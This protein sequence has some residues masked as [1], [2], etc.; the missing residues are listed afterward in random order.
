MGNILILDD[1]RELL[2]ELEI[3]L[4]N[5]GH[6]P[7]CC[8]NLMKARKA[9]NSGNEFHL[10]ILDVRLDSSDLDERGGFRFAEEI[11]KKTTNL[12]I[13]FVTAVTGDIERVRGRALGCWD[14]I[15]KSYHTEEL[16]LVI[17]NILTRTNQI[18]P[19]NDIRK[20]DLIISTR[21]QYVEWREQRFSPTYTE[22]SLIVKLGGHAG[23]IVN[24]YD[25]LE[26][27]ESENL[28]SV[29]THIRNI[30]KQFQKIAAPNDLIE[31]I[32]KVGYRLNVGF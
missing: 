25:L 22:M 3:H 16:R 5:W 14:Y 26:C 15:P 11:Q 29:Y 1:D 13:I 9:L 30:R 28:D 20:G 19:E 12:P 10:A 24:S 27:L 32:P 31:T 8:E 6:E 4:R 17:N 7:V 23:S 21:N 2:K 18:S